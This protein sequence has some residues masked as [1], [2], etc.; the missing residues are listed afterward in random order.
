MAEEALDALGWKLACH[1][2][3][4]TIL[5]GT[6]EG[7][8]VTVALASAWDDTVR[9]VLPLEARDLLEVPTASSL[10]AA[11]PSQSVRL[12][13]VRQRGVVGSTKCRVIFVQLPLEV[14]TTFF[15]PSGDEEEVLLFT[16]R[17]KNQF[18]HHGDIAVLTDNTPSEGEGSGGRV[19]HAALSTARPVVPSLVVEGGQSGGR[20]SHAAVSPAR[21]AVH[22]P[23]VG[24][25]QGR[26]LESLITDLASQVSN[27]MQELRD[28]IVALEGRPVT[29]G[30]CAAT[31]FT[32]GGPPGLERGTALAEAH[33]VV[34]GEPFKPDRP[35]TVP[36]STPPDPAVLLAS[37]LQKLMNKSG[38]SGYEPALTSAGTLEELEA[39]GLGSDGLGKLG[40]AQL[41]RLRLTRE[42]HPELI[43]Q[44][45]ERE[46]VRELGVLPN[47]GW[48][49]TRHAQ[50]KVMPSASGHHGLRKTI[51]I[52]AHALD[53]HRVKSPEHARAFLAQ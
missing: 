52:L 11:Y 39:I 43:I 22:A 21:P 41:E 34:T 24:E 51:A 26:S 17:S 7:Q 44:S 15:E 10:E 14:V 29:A 23:A 18:P 36:Q 5:V 12:A 40:A 16:S 46:L 1:T 49:Y 28:R 32:T 47:E 35:P 30:P 2:P 8:Q 20:V 9:C 48:S 6:F 38:A 31:P 37:A 27:N 3:D 45:Q 25:G 33:Q 4:Y 13:R 50:E 53:L 42:A 19:S